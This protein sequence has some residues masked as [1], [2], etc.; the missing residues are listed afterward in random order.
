MAE[1][2]ASRQVRLSYIGLDDADAARL[3]EM[4]AVVEDLLD[5]AVE[6]FY[7][8][9]LKFEVRSLIQGPEMLARL[10]AHQ[11]QY[12]VDLFSGDYG[13][14]YFRSR[15]RIGETH[16]RIGLEP[17]WYLGM[18]RVYR[19]V[20]VPRILERFGD[21]TGGAAPY[22]MALEKVLVLDGELALDAYILAHTRHL[23]SLQDEVSERNA[24][25]K[26]YATGL[27][28]LVDARSRELRLSE[29]KYRGIV[30]HAA[31]AIVFID[32]D[33]I[34]RSW[35]RGATA[36]LGYAPD[37]I[38]GRPFTV[39]MPEGAAH[40]L[41]YIRGEMHRVGNIRNFETVRVARD[42]RKVHVSITRTLLRNEAGEPMGSAAILRDITAIRTFE[43]RMHRAERVASLGW[44]ASEIAHEVGTP[45]N[46][47]S[48]RAEHVLRGLPEGDAKRRPLEIIVAQID[49]ISRVM[50]RALQIVRDPR[51]P[52]GDRA[53]CRVVQVSQEVLEFFEVKVVSRRI[54][55]VRDM[56]DLCLSMNKADLEQVMV[57]L[58]QN[59]I[60]AMPDGGTLTISAHAQGDDGVLSVHDSGIGIEAA[61]IQKI[62]EPLFT[63]KESGR[64]TGL[65]LALVARIV[66]GHRGAIEVESEPGLGSVFRL[67]LPLSPAPVAT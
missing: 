33:E 14:A 38:L 25:L 21:A 49:R 11:R 13:E 2:E 66:K 54:A 55:V 30:E 16:V 67:R 59:A 18:Y 56:E 52:A 58:V 4:G 27:E 42:G 34:I 12:L 15:F 64:G 39:L 32:N 28:D 41:E 36:I 44:L 22:L 40:E 60:D 62:F 5:E 17:Q 3:R 61:N 23:R 47:I 1:D 8:H 57:N 26:R 20:F 53:G 51:E 10:K 7:E 31:D 48:G 9:L 37:E 46:V 63:T 6:R 43:E 50:Q 29:E 65:G 45:L 24:E 35:N 19:A